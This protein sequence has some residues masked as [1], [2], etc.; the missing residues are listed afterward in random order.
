MQSFLSCIDIQSHD[1]SFMVHIDIFF[2]LPIASAFRLQHSGVKDFY[3]QARVLFYQVERTISA[4]LKPSPTQSGSRAFGSGQ[5]RVNVLI[6]MGC[7]EVPPSIGQDQDTFIQE[8]ESKVAVE[9]LVGRQGLAII[10]RRLFHERQLE[11][12]TSTGSN[13]VESVSTQDSFQPLS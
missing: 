11:D 9:P 12:R 7:G 2:F 3:P 13:Y 10:A 1:D 6:V 5:S 4:F 8:G